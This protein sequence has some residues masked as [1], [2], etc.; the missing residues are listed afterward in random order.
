ML[1]SLVLLDI[2]NA[3]S[4]GPSPRDI[5]P[6]AKF[7]DTSLYSDQDIESQAE[8]SLLAGVFNAG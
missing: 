8:Y 4:P 3:V 1:C 2:I 7:F 5:N 6:A